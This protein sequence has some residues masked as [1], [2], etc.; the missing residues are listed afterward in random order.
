LPTANAP[1]P[2]SGS[3]VVADGSSMYVAPVATSTDDAITVQVSND[4]GATWTLRTVPGAPAAL[5]MSDSSY[6]TGAGT[7]IITSRDVNTDASAFYAGRDHGSR[8]E[9]IP[10]P[11]GLPDGQVGLI[12]M[13]RPGEYLAAQPGATTCYRSTDGQTWTRV[14][15]P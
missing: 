9:E 10:R 4:D 11:A 15:L 13:S 5:K 3:G 7:H 2:L 12:R 8:Y 14:T 6:V 1:V